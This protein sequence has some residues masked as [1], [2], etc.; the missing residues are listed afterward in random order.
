MKRY[1]IRPYAGQ[2]RAILHTLART[3]NILYVGG[4]DTLVI[5]CSNIT[6]QDVR[7]QTAAIAIV[8]ELSPE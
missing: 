2:M 4:E 1:E 7:R 8:K 6:A 3:P 5:E